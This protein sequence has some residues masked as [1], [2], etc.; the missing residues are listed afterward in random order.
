L[1]TTKQSEWAQVVCRPALLKDTADMLELTRHIWEGNDYLPQVWSDW[2]AD[3]E[4]FLAVAEFNGRVVGISM[5]ECFQPGE[6]YLAGLRVHP[7]MEGHRIAGRLHEY[8]LEYWYRHHGRGV[9]RL[10]THNPK[11][12]HLCERTGFHCIGEFTIFVSPS[13]PETVETFTPL[14]ADQ[15][16]QALK[17]TYSS[18]VFDWHARLYGHGWSWCDPQP[19]YIVEAIE[20]GR[21]WLWQ[22]GLGVLVT[23]EDSNE[24]GSVPVISLLGCPEKNLTDL[25]LDYRRLAGMQGN[26]QASWVASLHPEL[27]PYL[28]EAGFHRDWDKALSVYELSNR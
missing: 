22:D 15:V 7:E 10:A 13:L 2:L 28:L 8:M 5:L 9:I 11:V 3:S 17:L 26:K 23:E 21:A 20:K 19:K 1:N 12:K 4:G 6:W 18:P 27:Q 14:L 25:L 24:A 16:D